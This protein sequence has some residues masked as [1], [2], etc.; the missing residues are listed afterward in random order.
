MSRP[1]SV[2]PL[3]AHG[4]D[5]DRGGDR[6]QTGQQ[7]EEQV[8]RAD[9]AGVER[10]DGA[11]AS[12]RRC[13]TREPGQVGAGES[14]ALPVEELVER[15]VHPD[16]DDDARRGPAW[17]SSRATSSVVAAD[18]RRIGRT[19]IR[20]RLVG[21]RAPAAVDADTTSRAA[22]SAL[23]D[24]RSASSSASPSTTMSGFRPAARMAS[25][26]R[27]TPM[28]TGLLLAEELRDR[29]QLGLGAR[30][31]RRPP[32][33]DGRRSGC[34][35]AAAPAR[36]AGGPARGGG[37]RV[38]LWVNVS[39]WV[40]R[41]RRASVHLV[42][43]DRPASTSRP[44]ATASLADVDDLVVDPDASR[45]RWTAS[46]PSTRSRSTMPASASTSGP[47]LG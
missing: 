28:S 24:G 18:S 22:R 14:G 12:T 42:L 35:S 3:L 44:I 11:R 16:A 9:P 4:R 7:H 36:A 26:P 34:A 39:S 13:P 23:A 27:S 2:G 41:P 43:D 20:S 45:R 29:G 31:P 25:A 19:P 37:T 30:G 47:R 21:V 5:G 15:G 32:R 8:A 40:A 46:V 10:R 38:L 17:A 33:P 1:S 6:D